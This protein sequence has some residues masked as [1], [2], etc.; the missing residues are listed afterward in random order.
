MEG[1]IANVQ[2]NITSPML[3]ENKREY[4]AI[5][6]V[7]A[8]MSV[9][10]GYLFC[11]VFPAWIN[12]LSGMLFVLF[13]YVG[14]TII[15]KIN[16]AKLEAKAVVTAMS[17]VVVGVSLVFTSNQF[18]ELIAYTYSLM[19]YCYYVFV[20]LGNTTK[21]G[22]NDFI[23]VD[24]IK[25]LLFA[26]FNS[27]GSMF[28]AIFSD[29]FKKSGNV[30]WKVV[31]G[32]TIAMIPTIIVTILLSYDDGFR[33]IMGNLFDF[34]IGDI[35]SEGMCIVFGMLVGMYIF[36]LFISSVDKTCK[37]FSATECETK[38]R[39]IQC[40]HIATAIAAVIPILFLYVV[41]FISQWKFYMYGFSGKLP[42]GFS[43]S[44]YAREG[45]FQLCA[46][47]VINLIII[48]FVMMFMNQE[49]NWL[50]KV[51]ASIVV[52]YAVVTLI[53]IATAVA[54]MVMY[55]DCYGLTPKRVYATW[56]M[57]VL[58]M[59]FF[60]I[61]LK[62][63][64]AKLSAVSTSIWITVVMFSML[65]LSNVEGV[66]A[67]YNISKFLD[68]TFNSID[69]DA[70]ADMGDAAIPELVYLFEELKK[71]DKSDENTGVYTAYMETGFVLE[72]KA[73]EYNNEAK[74]IMSYTIP[75]YKAINS[76]EDAGFMNFE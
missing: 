1:V 19:A 34:D 5:E 33:N 16:K 7:F 35:I 44:S 62:Q 8:W 64:I 68:G 26:P 27:I 17:G 59:I 21:K 58:I 11:K 50:K 52:T 57:I 3:I 29:K 73:L 65:A 39:K 14:T 13:L 20:A 40:I 24:Y 9:I 75:Y 45:F 66:I 32:V 38:V 42:E 48:V 54:K 72:D 37:E 10:F 12:P 30:I 51:R 53:L 70:V 28:K 60:T 41:F 23:L 55:I 43:Y 69:V 56:M 63:F 61:I 15:L 36:E 18:I 47:S 6:T 74:D 22:F 71:M 67:R 2:Q 31:L 49:E 76:L 4:T 25:A 46:V